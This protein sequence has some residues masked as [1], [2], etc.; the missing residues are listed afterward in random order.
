M[1]RPHMYL[2]HFAAANQLKMGT[3]VLNG[4]VKT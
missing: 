4:L 1:S 2:R 3:L